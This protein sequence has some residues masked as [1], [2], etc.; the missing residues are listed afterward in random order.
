VEI[1]NV[2]HRGLRRFIENDDASGL[3]ATFIEKIR[4]IVSFL[5]EMDDTEELKA[6]RS[7]HAHPLTGDRRGTWNLTI[8]RNW[9]Q[10]LAHHLYRR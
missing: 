8:T 5:Q 3:P 4:N 9:R 10:E 7:W 2:R 6:L 1:A